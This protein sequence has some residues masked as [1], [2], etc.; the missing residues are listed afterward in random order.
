MDP[1]SEKMEFAAANI[2]SRTRSVGAAEVWCLRSQVMEIPY[3]VQIV[4]SVE[5]LAGT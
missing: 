1:A 3:Y 4:Q 5:M 2:N